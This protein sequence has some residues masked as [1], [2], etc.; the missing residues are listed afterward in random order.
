MKGVNKMDDN[1]LD[2]INVDKHSIKYAIE[3]LDRITFNEAVRKVHEQYGIYGQFTVD[4]DTIDNFLLI[5][6][7][8]RGF[9]SVDMQNLLID[10]DFLSG[11]IREECI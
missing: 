9:D 5:P 6:R 8:D 10:I 2:G 4:G 7:T 3:D 11:A 1:I